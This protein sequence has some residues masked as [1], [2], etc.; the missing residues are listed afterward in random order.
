M[1]Q[2][3]RKF[4]LQL[5]LTIQH[6]LCVCLRAL[7]LRL[8]NLIHLCWSCDFIIIYRSVLFQ[9]LAQPKIY[10]YNIISNHISI[11]FVFL[12]CKKKKQQIIMLKMRYR[13]DVKFIQ[14]LSLGKITTVSLHSSVIKNLV[15]KMCESNW[16]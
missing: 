13:S 4:F 15:W 12:E 2:C 14:C 8:F 9:T 16:N 7:L 1:S 3:V 10:I 6:F 5:K 11:H